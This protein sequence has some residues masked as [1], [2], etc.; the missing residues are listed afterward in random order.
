MEGLNE[1]PFMYHDL[2]IQEKESPALDG[3]VWYMI[4]G[5]NCLNQGVKLICGIFGRDLD[6]DGRV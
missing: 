3:V 2:N 1:E 4:G 6:V 5:G